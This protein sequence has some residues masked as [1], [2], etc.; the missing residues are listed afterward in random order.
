[1]TGSRSR[2]GFKVLG[3][4]L[5]VLCAFEACSSDEGAAP[6]PFTE[7][8]TLEVAAISLGTG[9]GSVLACDNNIGVTLA[10]SNWRLEPP[11]KCG[12]TPQC[13]QVRVS[14]LD[15]PNGPELASTSSAAIGVNLDLT[16][17]VE[18]GTLKSG[19]YAIQAELVDDTGHAYPIT[20]GGNNTAARAFTLSLSRS[21]AS[22]SAGASSGGASGEGGM[23]GMPSF[24]SGGAGDAL[25]GAGGAAPP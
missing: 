19:S 20:D 1:M 12:S 4:S 3:A 16:P 13:G 15:G 24:E 21:C 2:Q 9:D 7:P 14:L 25:A 5:L 17:L 6:N 18:K 8:P 22:G 11:G 10:L 23:G